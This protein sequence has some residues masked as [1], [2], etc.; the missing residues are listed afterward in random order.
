MEKK[1]HGLIIDQ[2]SIDSALA[3]K[4]ALRSV[5]FND[6]VLLAMYMPNYS[7]FLVSST[8]F[9][10]SNLLLSVDLHI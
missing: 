2:P 5:V 10:I 1:K 7:L 6:R 9:T 4:Q 8:N 3:N